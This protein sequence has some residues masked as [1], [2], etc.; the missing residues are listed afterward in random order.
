LS[1]KTLMPDA[2]PAQGRKPRK[3]NELARA[4]THT[5][6]ARSSDAWQKNQR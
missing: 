5:C 1:A 6:A 4:G 3:I 2:F